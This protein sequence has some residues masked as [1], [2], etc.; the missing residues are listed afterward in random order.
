MKKIKLMADFFCYP[1]WYNSHDSDYEVGDFDPNILPI[2]DA[3]KKELLDWSNEYDGIFN[4]DDPASSNFKNLEDETAFIK[5]G[6][7]LQKKLQA[8]LGNAYEVTYRNFLK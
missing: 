2:S 3:L 4:D 5:Q 8:E 6:D 1:L 7:N